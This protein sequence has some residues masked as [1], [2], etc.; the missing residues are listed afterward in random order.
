MTAWARWNQ[1]AEEMK[2]LAGRDEINVANALGEAGEM[3]WAE[4][5]LWWACGRPPG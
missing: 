5:F 3:P 2:D 4:K 1:M